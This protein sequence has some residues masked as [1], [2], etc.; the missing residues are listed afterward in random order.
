MVSLAGGR[1]IDGH[2]DDLPFP[3][4]MALV[5]GGLA[6][7]TM[8]LDLNDSLL[9]DNIKL[10]LLKEEVAGTATSTKRSRRTN[11]K[12]F[13]DNGNRRKRLVLVRW[14]ESK[15]SLTLFGVGLLHMGV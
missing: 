4:P 7:D 9:D 3:T 8:V 6:E 5:A 13:T 1:V 15:C 12:I 10:G 2:A 14:A 11:D